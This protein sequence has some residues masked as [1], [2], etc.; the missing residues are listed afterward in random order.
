MISCKQSQKHMSAYIQ[1]N[2][3]PQLQWQVSQHIHHCQNC[4]AVYL[5]EKRLITDLRRVVPKIG[6]GQP[7]A[8]ERVWKATQAASVRRSPPQYSLRYGMA[9]LVITFLLLIPFAMGK[10]NQVFAE[11]PTQ[12]APLVRVTPN[13]T[14]AIQ[15]GVSV[16]F[17]IRQ[18][19]APARPPVTLPVDAIS[20][21]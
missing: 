2:L 16:A 19:P 6:S 12:P 1:R 11:P 7:P 5:E 17:E 13:G 14:A 9:M 10:G 15:E 4:Y 3:P 18:T 8:F 21:P 20:T